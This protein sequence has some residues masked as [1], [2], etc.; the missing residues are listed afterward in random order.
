[1]MNH[2]QVLHIFL[3][4]FDYINWELMQEIMIENYFGY[5]AHRCKANM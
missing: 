2:L 1:M 4:Y 5:S 3:S